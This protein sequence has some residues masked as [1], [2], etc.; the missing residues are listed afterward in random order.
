MLDLY[1]VTWIGVLEIQSNEKEAYGAVD[2]K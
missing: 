1:L 2:S